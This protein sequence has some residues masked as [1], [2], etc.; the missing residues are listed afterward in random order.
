[1]SNDVLCQFMKATLSTVLVTMRSERHASKAH[2]WRN[3]WNIFCAF[4]HLESFC[5]MLFSVLSGKEGKEIRIP[6]KEKKERSQND[7]ADK[8]RSWGKT[9]IHINCIY[10]SKM[11]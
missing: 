5:Q 9:G 7:K 11:S 2:V 10:I 4:Y 8:D 6:I 1:M 3:P